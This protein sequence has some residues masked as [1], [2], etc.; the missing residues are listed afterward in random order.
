MMVM[1]KWFNII[2]LFNLSF[3]AWSYVV[4]TVGF[5]DNFTSVSEGIGSFE[6]CVRIFT[7]AELLP[8]MFEFSLELTTAANTAGT[9]VHAL[10]YIIM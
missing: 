4:I 9:K 7:A 6:L 10:Q 8:E 5:E 1:A 2:A 3:S